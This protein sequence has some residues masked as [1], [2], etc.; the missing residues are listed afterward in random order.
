MRSIRILLVDDH[1]MFREMLRIPLE[2]EPGFNV[3]GEAGSGAQ[4]LVA[5]EALCPDVAVLDIAL[6]DMSGIEVAKK[7]T[8]MHPRCHIV[9]LSGYADR[10]FVD[11]M[12]SAGAHAYVLKSSGIVELSMAIRAVVAGHDFMSPEVAMMMARS[13]RSAKGSAPPVTVLTS[14][15]RDVLRLIGRG[16]RTAEI[17]AQF[18]ISTLTVDVHRRNIRHKLNLQTTAE[19]TRYAVREGLLPL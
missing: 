10:V 16:L 15:E 13:T 7:I 3:V 9:A 12:L 17:A 19:L 8:A 1:R 14:R 18:D 4:A 5:V 6:P 11:E 2:A